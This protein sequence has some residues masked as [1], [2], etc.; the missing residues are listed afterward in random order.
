MVEFARRTRK[1][2]KRK[3]HQAELEHQQTTPN[4]QRIVNNPSQMSHEDAMQLQRQYGNAFV[5]RLV[6]GQGKD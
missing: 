4:I 3:K 5:Q 6:Q 1:K 2:R